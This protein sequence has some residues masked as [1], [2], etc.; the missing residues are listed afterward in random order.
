MAS[1]PRSPS[2]GERHIPSDSLFFRHLNLRLT[3]PTRMI[4]TTTKMTMKLI[5][6]KQEKECGEGER[7]SGDKRKQ[8][9]SRIPFLAKYYIDRLWE[10]SEFHFSAQQMSC[11]LAVPGWR[12]LC[13]LDPFCHKNVGPSRAKK[14]WLE[15][16]CNL[17]SINA[18]LIS[19]SLPE[20]MGEI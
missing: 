18:L 1:G 17:P 10:Q 19:Q 16:Q 15:G 11:W 12:G 4:T 14:S 7:E 5:T 6:P 13:S 20:Q 9:E 2:T 8:Q 3:T